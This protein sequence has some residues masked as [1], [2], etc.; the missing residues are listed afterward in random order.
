[1]A[2]LHASVTN[3]ITYSEDLAGSN[4]VFKIFMAT[5]LNKLKWVN[6]EIEIRLPFESRLK[7]RSVDHLKYDELARLMAHMNK[8]EQAQ[9]E[10][11]A[12]SIYKKK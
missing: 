7:A 10:E 11:F 8:E 9:L 2:L 3:A 5:L 4:P 6:R 1:M 12:K